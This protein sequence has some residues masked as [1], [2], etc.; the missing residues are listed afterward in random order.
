M[1]EPKPYET[2][3]M[4]TLEY[5]DNTGISADD[6]LEISGKEDDCGILRSGRFHYSL[7]AITQQSYRSFGYNA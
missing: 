1:N 2:V 4:K 7:E 6:F 3:D 5:W